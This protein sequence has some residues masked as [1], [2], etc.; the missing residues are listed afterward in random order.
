MKHF[1]FR[2]VVFFGLFGL[3]AILCSASAA[4]SAADF[5]TLRAKAEKGNPVAQYNL[6]LAYADLHESFYD[7]IEAYVWLNLAASNGTMGKALAAIIDTMTPAQ[8]AEGQRRFTARH[9]VPTA[10]AVPASPIAVPLAA[11]EKPAA[12]AVAK[13]ADAIKA[14]LNAQLADANKR[15]AIAQAAL[16]SKD[17]TIASLQ[18]QL[19]AAPAP[20]TVPSA[21]ELASV[22]QQLTQTADALVVARRSQSLSEAEAASLKAT[23]DKVSAERLAIAAQLE[24]TMN[25][26]ARLRAELDAAK[27]S[28][29]AVTE[30]REKFTAAAKTL[31]DTQAERDTLSHQLAD[32]KAAPSTPSNVAAPPA[33][34]VAVPATTDLG[35]LPA[36]LAEVEKVR[37]ETQSNLDAA[38]RTYTLN[39]AEIERLQKSLAIIEGERADAAA[40]LEAATKELVTLRPQAEVAA[41]SAAQVATLSAQLAAAQLTA[42]DRAATI[43]HAAQDLAAA[44]QT[45]SSAANELAAVREQLR[46]TQAQSAS[47][48]NE[49]LELKTRLSLG[50]AAVPPSRPGS[51]TIFPTPVVVTSPVVSLPVATPAVGP[52]K[53]EVA[54]APEVRIHVV[55]PGDSLS[56]IAKRYYG[57]AYRWNDILEA[58]RNTLR[59]AD[60]LTLGTKLRIP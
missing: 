29:P 24:N 18:G 58:N 30:L 9:A 14:S 52:T 54:S 21:A 27:L 41:A 4:T 37:A 33:A 15:L 6:G 47:A 5:T 48:A 32:A 36:H 51:N 8:L 35:D 42:A 46:L 39:Q 26:V 19:T 10:V 23:A 17:K 60:T 50:T 22:R 59:N 3:V 55:S 34:P 7:P 43:D 28:D 25:E 13:E 44:R 31:A 1:P 53:S 12:V 16:A 56:S 45:A 20:A 57:N 11:P 38:L 49:V 40:K 2:H